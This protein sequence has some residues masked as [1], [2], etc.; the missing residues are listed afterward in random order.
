MSDIL[1]TGCISAGIHHLTSLPH[2]MSCH[3][4]FLWILVFIF[5]YSEHIFFLAG[6]VTP[7][8][9]WLALEAGL[10]SGCHGSSS[11]LA[12]EYQAVLPT[13]E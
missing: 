2:S 1:N 9:P 13:K 4:Q 6:Y 5:L 8:I 7:K 10:G 3:T 11:G 12:G